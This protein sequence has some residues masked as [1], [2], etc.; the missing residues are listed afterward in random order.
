MS[1]LQTEPCEIRSHPPHRWYLRPWV[2]L[3]TTIVLGASAIGWPICLKLRAIAAFNN[4]EFQV[5]FVRTV[6][7]DFVQRAFAWLPPALYCD[8]VTVCGRLPRD[9]NAAQQLIDLLPQISPVVSLT[10]SAIS[11]TSGIAMA[12]GPASTETTVWVSS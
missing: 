9:P 10:L 7:P 5:V 12:W 3:L 8:F 4:A 2:L 1:P 6:E 11:A